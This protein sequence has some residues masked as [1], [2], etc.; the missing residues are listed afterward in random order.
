MGSVAFTRAGANQTEDGRTIQRDPG[1]VPSVGRV[2]YPD[3]S[4]YCSVSRTSS[5]TNPHSRLFIIFRAS[6]RDIASVGLTARGAP[7][8]FTYERI[9]YTLNHA[10]P[11]EPQVCFAAADP[12]CCAARRDYEYL[13]IVVHLIVSDPSGWDWLLALNSAQRRGTGSQNPLFALHRHP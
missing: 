6:L 10:T 3:G 12:G 11:A 1:A 9:R 2:R 5:V 7:D 4:P 8:L 13:T